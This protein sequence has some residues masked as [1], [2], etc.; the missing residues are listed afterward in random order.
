LNALA[1]AIS[2]SQVIGDIDLGDVQSLATFM[3]DVDLG[4]NVDR[5]DFVL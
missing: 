3:A 1:N 4:R 5:D 2:V